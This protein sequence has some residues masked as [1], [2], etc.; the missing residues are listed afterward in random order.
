MTSTA[1]EF[2]GAVKGT[3]VVLESSLN[4]GK[5]KVTEPGIP[6]GIKKKGVH[7]DI[8]VRVGVRD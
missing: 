7:D 5:R 1:A 3:G 8:K 6:S 4:K 2:G